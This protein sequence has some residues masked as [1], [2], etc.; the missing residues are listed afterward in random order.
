MQNCL[1]GDN[2]ALSVYQP[3]HILLLTQSQHERFKREYDNWYKYYTPTFLVIWLPWACYDYGVRNAPEGVNPFWFAIPLI[4]GAAIGGIIGY[5]YHR[6]AVN[7]AKSI[8]EQNE[9]V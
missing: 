4:V 8:I 7:A 2:F 5:R 6:K 9:S 3:I 1:L